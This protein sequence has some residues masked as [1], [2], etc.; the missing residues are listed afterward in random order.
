MPN[1]EVVKN[2]KNDVGEYIVAKV[3]RDGGT[4]KLWEVGTI[5]NVPDEVSQ[6]KAD[7]FVAS[8]NVKF[9]GKKKMEVA[10]IAPKYDIPE[11]E[12]FPIRK[13]KTPKEID[14]KKK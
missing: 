4:T 13:E 7:E 9:T 14:V 5:L 2:Y 6:Y 12:E 3:F 11:D 10:E 1:F 8:G